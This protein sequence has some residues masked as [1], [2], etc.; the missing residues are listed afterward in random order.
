MP[1]RLSEMIERPVSLADAK[2][3]LRV[4]STHDDALI[5]GILDACALDAGARMNRSAALCQ[6]VLSLSEFPAG[7]IQLMHP[8]VSRV[9]SVRYSDELG[10][11]Q[12]LPAAEYRLDTGVEPNVLRA[13]TAW[14]KAGRDVVVTYQAGWGEDAPAT[15][16]QWILLQA[17][18]YYRNREAASE[19]GL[20]PV[21]YGDSL[22]DPYRLIEV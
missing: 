3:H 9:L 22:L 13:V 21:P 10:Q 8:P 7:G 2:L 6:W 20:T 12:T 11:Q 16:R 4:D 1:T 17:A 19:K 15:V 18:H 14:P 5:E